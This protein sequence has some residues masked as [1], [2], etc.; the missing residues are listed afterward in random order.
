MAL[1]RV[2]C[3]GC[4]VVVGGDVVFQNRE[5]D[6]CGFHHDDVAVWQCR[7]HPS[8]LRPVV[9]QVVINGCS[10]YSGS[11]AFC[12]VLRR[13]MLV[14]GR[15]GTVA[16]Y[17]FLGAVGVDFFIRPDHVFFA[18]DFVAV[19]NAV[20]VV[21]NVR[22]GYCCSARRQRPY[23]QAHRGQ[24]VSALRLDPAFEFA[25]AYG[26]HG[27]G[28]DVRRVADFFLDFGIGRVIGHCTFLP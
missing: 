6:A 16:V 26:N 5:R 11:V 27:G 21:F 14:H 15:R 7:F 28:V 17:R 18:A 24:R 3:I 19:R 8:A 1:L 2:H 20:S 10:S 25:V 23:R 9:F 13:R 12:A 22:L 4:L